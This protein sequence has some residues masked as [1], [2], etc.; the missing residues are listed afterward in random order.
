M[1]MNINA[2]CVAVLFFAGLAHADVPAYATIEL[3]ARTNLLV[4]DNGWNL[5]PG[6]SFNSISASLNDD[7]QVAFTVGVIPDGGDSHPGVWSGAHGVGALV[8]E[9]PGGAGISSESPINAGGRIVFTL[10]DTGSADGL[11]VY[12]PVAGSAS[13][14]NTLPV[15]PN[16]YS[17]PDINASGALGYQAVFSGGR[18]LASTL[19]AN[20]VLHVADAG[21]SPGSP[22]TYIY[23][24][25]F[26]EARRIAAKVATSADLTTQHEI[27]R[28]DA[29][30]ESVRILANQATDPASPYARFDNGLAISPDGTVAVIGVRAA[31]NRRVVVRS[32]GVTTTEIAA[33]DPVGTIRDL[34]FFAPAINASGLVAF[35][36]RD[37]AGQAIYV[38]DGTRLV[39]VVGQSTAVATDLGPGQ[40]GQHDSSAIFAGKPDINARGDI[41]FVAALHPAGNNQVEWGSGVFVAYASADLVFADGFDTTAPP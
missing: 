16:S 31:D 15:I 5:P 6:S 23:T 22:Y 20:T 1:R 8:F 27:R 11:Y 12:D 7:A 4:N 19:G 21:V 30:G 37:A 32:D 10:R 29:V 9:A 34:D 17:S 14:I 26:D 39:R 3:Q 2:G 41:A 35:R 36:A 18:A 40:V 13:R 38:G 28:F 24:P 33:V 25:A